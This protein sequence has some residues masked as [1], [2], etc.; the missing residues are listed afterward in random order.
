MRATLKF[1][2]TLNGIVTEKIVNCSCPVIG[3]D[4]GGSRVRYAMRNESLLEFTESL[5]GTEK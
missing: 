3:C 2:V 5:L 1:K 4:G